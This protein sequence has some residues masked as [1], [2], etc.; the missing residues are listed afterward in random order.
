M[1]HM[2]FGDEGRDKAEFNMAVSY[3]NRINLL[4]SA[5]DQASISLDIYSWFHSLLATYREL[6]TWMKPEE[7]N[8]FN[9]TVDDINPAISQIYAK[10]SR[11]GKIEIPHNIYM[12]LHNMEIDLRSIAK[13][14]GLLMKM[15]EDGY[16]A[17]K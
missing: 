16:D 3:L 12:M 13:K 15:A 5:C 8:K 4:F 11:G 6:S 9:K 7:I 10:S 1:K 14:A 2:A 17:L